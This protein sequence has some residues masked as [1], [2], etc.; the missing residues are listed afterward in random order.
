VSS[1]DIYLVMCCI[2]SVACVSS[3]PQM[4][5][6]LTT[7]AGFTEYHLQVECDVSTEVGDEIL[8][9]VLMEDGEEA[10]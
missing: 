3:G 8:S 5:G 6:F 9:R 4:G 1:T 7:M 2:L 10:A